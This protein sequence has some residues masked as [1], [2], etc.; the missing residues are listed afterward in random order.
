M[1]SSTWVYRWG[2]R[3]VSC[4]AGEEIAASEEDPVLVLEYVRLESGCD[5]LMP[6]VPQLIRI[7]LPLD[8]E[9]DNTP[10]PIV[11]L[12]PTFPLLELGARL[13]CRLPNP[14][15]ADPDVLTG[16]IP[17]SLV[18]LGKVSRNAVE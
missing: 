7:P 12:L 9:G 13:V 18:V 15:K 8:N 17:G 1:R 14:H 16:L 3:C 2:G 4:D 6:L 10:P 5:P 11:V